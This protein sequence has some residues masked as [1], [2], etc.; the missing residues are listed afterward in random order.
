MNN[1]TPQQSLYISEVSNLETFKQY[2]VPAIT[3]LGRKYLTE[4]RPQI[5]S[6]L[7]KLVN[8]I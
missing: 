2:E 3:V 7:L 5:I 6:E 8:S 1:L 4:E